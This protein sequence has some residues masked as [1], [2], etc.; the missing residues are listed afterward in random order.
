MADPQTGGC[1]CG[2][3]TYRVT[4]PLRPV[5]ACH[6]NQCRKTSGHFV[7]ATSALREDVVIEG[8]PHWYASS[9]TAKR[10]FC[11]TCG[12]PL[13]WDPA[14][15]DRLSIHAGSLDTPTGLTT[16]GHIF[17]AEKGDYYQIVDGLPQAPADDPVLTTQR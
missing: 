8:E 2:R 11:P 7:A 12:S 15:G 17:T 14:E 16:A 1:L 4:G 6:C 5:V 13:F 10:G 3:I 9:P